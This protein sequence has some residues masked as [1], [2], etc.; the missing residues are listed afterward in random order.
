[1][2]DNDKSREKISKKLPIAALVMSFLSIALVVIGRLMNTFSNAPIYSAEADFIRQISM[3][4]MI[5][6]ALVSS[7]GFLL[8]IIALIKI[9]RKPAVYGGIGIAL[10]ALILNGILFLISLGLVFIFVSY[11]IRYAR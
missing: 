4:I 11:A 3:A 10:I 6:I 8:S 1:M 5:G 2:F 7:V 9:L